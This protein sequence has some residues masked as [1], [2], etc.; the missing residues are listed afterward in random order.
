MSIDTRELIEICEQLPETERAQV[1]DFARFLLSR[2]DD[3]K[4]EQTLA[5]NKPRPKLNDFVQAAL[6]EGSE[7]IDDAAFDREL[8]DGEKR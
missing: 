4:W 3:L 2:H 1:A 7:P 5:D 8:G 6:A